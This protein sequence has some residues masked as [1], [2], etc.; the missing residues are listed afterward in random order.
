MKQSNLKNIENYDS[1]LPVH[2]I[3]EHLCNA[4]YRPFNYEPY[5]EKHTPARNLP[6]LY[7]QDGSIFVQDS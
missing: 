2:A 7:M 4:D 3:K 6:V 5:A 1:L